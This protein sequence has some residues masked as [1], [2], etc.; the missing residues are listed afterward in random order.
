MKIAFAL[1][2][3]TLAGCAPLMPAKPIIQTRTVTVD[4]PVFV[5]L[6][7]YLTARPNVH[8]DTVGDSWRAGLECYAKLD[9]IRKLQ[10]TS[11]SASAKRPQQ[12][13]PPKR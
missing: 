5:P 2:L 9:A 8:V 13:A 3:A 10:P 1:V 11:S 7:S 4:V 6:P 12:T